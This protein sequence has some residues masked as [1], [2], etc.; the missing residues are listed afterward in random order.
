MKKEIVV[1]LI[2]ISMMLVTTTAVLGAK[3]TEDFWDI[4]SG[5]ITY[6]D[7]VTPIEIGYDQ[8]GYNYQ[9]HMFNGYYG[10]AGRP[11]TPVTSGT[12]LQMKWND[13]WLSNKDY[14]HDGDTLLDRHYGF[15]TYMDSGAWLT[16]HQSGEY[17]V[18]GKY[19]IG[20]T[21]L[22]SG[23][24]AGISGWSDPWTWGGNYG[25]ADDQTFRLLMGPGDGCGDGYRDAYFTIDTGGAYMDTIDLQHLDGSQNDNF[26]LFMLTGYTTVEPIV[27]IWTQIGN[28]YIGG[29]GVEHWVTS[30]Y[31]FNPV[32]GE[33]EFKLLATG[34]VTSWCSTW[35]QVA[36]SW[37]EWSGIAYWNYF[38]KIIAVPS[39]ATLT[40]GIW[41]TADGIAIG[42]VIWGQFAIIQQVEN[43]P[44]AGTHGLQYKGLAPTGFGIY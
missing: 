40:S 34:T 22:Y 31:T 44:Y 15:P 9:A 12:W 5:M 37:V 30:T 39:D 13:A 14:K 27:P 26:K 28:E 4:K 43:D 42:P 19:D 25:G 38:V 11:T 24:V 2:A 18:T 29:Q 35:G 8:W 16:N 10:N 36:F 41:Y 1:A 32:C 20:G 3:P 21:L 33:I 23:E 7:G 17:T 6:T